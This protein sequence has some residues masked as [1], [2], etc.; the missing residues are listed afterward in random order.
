MNLNSPKSEPAKS[1]EKPN[2]EKAE[3][4]EIASKPGQ[5]TKNKTKNK[6]E[7]SK[8]DP[9]KEPKHKIEHRKI[10]HKAPSR[11]KIEP[12]QIDSKKE[13]KHKI[14]CRKIDPK[15]PP[16]HKIEPRQIDPKKEPKH[17]IERRKID[18]KAPSRHKIEP[19]QI[20]IK[21]EPKNKIHHPKFDPRKPPRNKIELLEI[22]ISQES[23]NK[24]HY[25]EISHLTPPRNKIEYSKFDISKEQIN[26]NQHP[27]INLDK[28]H[29]EIKPINPHTSQEL[30]NKIDHI[31]NNEPENNIKFKLNYSGNLLNNKLQNELKEY[32]NQTGKY[33]NWGV[34]IKQ[35]FIKK[36]QEKYNNNTISDDEKNS[37]EGINQICKD[38][39]ANHEIQSYIIDLKKNKNFS[40]QQ[41]SR[42]L[43]EIGLNVSRSLVGKIYS[44]QT[45]NKVKFLTKNTKW[46]FL[47]WSEKGE[48]LSYKEQVKKAVLFLKSNILTTEF[49]EKY[50]LETSEAPL[51]NI[52]NIENKGFTNACSV[53]GLHYNDVLREAGLKVNMERSKWTFLDRDENGKQL[54]YKEKVE[55]AVEYLNDKILTAE[56]KEKYKLETSEAPIRELISLENKGFTNACSIR[57]LYYNDILRESGL[58]INMERNKWTFLDRDENGKQLS[59]KEKVKRAA[60]YLNDKILTAGFKAKFNIKKNEGPMISIL[61][62]ENYDFVSA[63]RHRNITHNDVLRKLGL[64]INM[65]SG[66][67]SFLD[68]N[69]KGESLL[70]EEQIGKAS[71]HLKKI[72]LT[73]E[74]RKHYNLDDKEGPTISTL[75]NDHSDYSSAIY[76]RNLSYNDIL[77]KSGYSAHDLQVH[78]DVGR[79]LHWIEE[80]VFLQHTRNLNCNSFY[81]VYPNIKTKNI[82]LYNKYGLKRCDNAIFIN[83]NCKKLSSEIKRLSESRPEIKM[84]NFDYF[85]GNSKQKIIEKCL[86]G[87]QDKNKMLILVPSHCSQPQ[88]PPEEVPYVENIKIMD[89]KTFANFIGYDGELREKFFH[90]LNIAKNALV[91]DNENR[92]LICQKGNEYKHILEDNYNYNQKELEKFIEKNYN[93]SENILKYVP[94]KSTLDKWLLKKIDD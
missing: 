8:I 70:Y 63:T 52:L 32:L 29:N 35:S 27:R 11:H 89:P 43:R 28:P 19:R 67:W 14:K 2:T 24:I 25:P 44:L 33:A 78:E 76:I 34:Q 73:K 37:F 22:D 54:S 92:E 4:S 3:K 80:S 82:D 26:K 56:F 60:E 93:V 69:E 75:N 94:D 38:I 15:A 16:I 18:P 48:Q 61:L 66:K 85:L 65:E 50:Q 12:R 31:P 36:V 74:Y 86:K 41:I 51:K 62:V 53:R 90:S 68:Y 87:Y 45:D 59:H 72:I 1:Y 7:P 23:R 46:S 5:K 81:E 58:K 88:E 64:K 83:D 79:A 47:D 6:T 42:E 9:K 57:S 10:D 49:K 84:I 30:R 13:P 77:I 40:N 91:D 71:E 17:K 21:K 39:N 20:D 55:R